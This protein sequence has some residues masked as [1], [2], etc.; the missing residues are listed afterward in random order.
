MDFTRRHFIQT[1]VA[2]SAAIALPQTFAQTVESTMARI[3]RMGRIRL[4]AINGTIPLF[5][6]DLATE[7]WKG[8]GVDFGNDLANYLK[9]DVEWIETTWGNAALDVRTGKIDAQF[10]LAATPQRRKVV[11]FS[12]SL[13]SNI[14]TVMAREELKF[15]TWRDLDKPEIKVAVDIGSSHDQFATRLLPNAN[16]LRFDNIATATM[17]LQ[18]GRADCQVLVALVS[19]P[20]QAK[21][22]NI[23]HIVFPTPEQIDF[24]GVAIRRQ[25]DQRFMSAVNNWLIELR[26]TGSIHDLIVSN[27]QSLAKVPPSVLPKQLR[28]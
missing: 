19:I 22:P 23:G 6:K 27:M 18:S 9:A 2:G 8:F 7:A 21:L 1:A 11:D 14:Y 20:L 17:A 4:G 26:R 13:Y 28:F 3:E 15:N 5:A 24:T 25:T 10:S 12:N 16:I